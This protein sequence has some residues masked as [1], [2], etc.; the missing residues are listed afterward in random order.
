VL[1]ILMVVAMQAEATPLLGRIGAEPAPL[2]TPLP[3]RAFTGSIDRHRVTVVV[4]GRHPRHGVDHIGT[5]AAALATM[6]GIDRFAP[7]LVLTAGTAGARR[8]SGLRLGEVVVASDRFVFHDRRI[9]IDGFRELGVGDVPA[10]DLDTI[11]A[12]L[13]FTTGVFSSGNSF[14]ETAE[15]LAMLDASG[16]I[17]IDMESAAV[18]SV[19]ELCGVPVGGVRVIVNHID[20]AEASVAEF[21]DGLEDAAAT[22]ADALVA[23]IG[24]IDDGGSSVGMRSRSAP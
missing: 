5:D 18:A 20:D 2:A 13:G 3:I 21:A 4:N 7:D 1:S 19:A 17:A 12:V 10:A 6:V 14:G 8:R 22:L 15:D 23:V 16:A 11:A 24:A 9:P